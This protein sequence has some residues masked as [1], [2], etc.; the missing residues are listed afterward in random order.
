MKTVIETQTGW[1][2]RC[3]AC[4]W[5]EFPKIGQSSANWSFNGDMERPTF[6]PSMNQ[7]TNSPDSKYYN[8]ECESSRC[9]F[10]LREG[11]IQYCDD[12]THELR[13]QSL[14]LQPWDETKIKYY[15]MLKE[16]NQW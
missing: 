15:D 10:I 13:G 11:I 16:T 2:I 1:M 9:H 5:H 7:M 4:Q 6:S 3:Q 8:P 12:C 14:P